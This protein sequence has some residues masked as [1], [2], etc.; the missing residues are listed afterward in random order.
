MATA[1]KKILCIEDDRESAALIAEELAL[2]STS[3]TS[4][5]ND[6]ARRAPNP[7]PREVQPASPFFYGREIHR[8]A[9][10]SL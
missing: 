4:L 10:Y 6:P 9:A 3:L 5:R 2:R 8:V 7:Q 1:R